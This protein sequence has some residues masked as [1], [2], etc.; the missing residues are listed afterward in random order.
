MPIGDAPPRIT[1]AIAFCHAVAG[2]DH[3]F[4]GCFVDLHILKAGLSRP[5]R[6]EF[7]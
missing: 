3:G 6:E 4:A 5:G 2:D 7:C 1:A